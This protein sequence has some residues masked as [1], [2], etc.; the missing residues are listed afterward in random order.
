MSSLH[1]D[2]PSSRVLISKPDSLGQDI[3]QAP[4][5]LRSSYKLS[6]SL[7][8]MG[9]KMWGGNILARFLVLDS[10]TLTSVGPDMF[11]AVRDGAATSSLLLVKTDTEIT[12][13]AVK[14]KSSKAVAAA[15]QAR[16]PMFEM[17]SSPLKKRNLI[18]KL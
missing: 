1:S 2:I 3:M 9:T 4:D 18:S 5:L 6:C 12:M 15:S 16:I 17:K 7:E 14:S 8:L 10:T 13:I 11:M